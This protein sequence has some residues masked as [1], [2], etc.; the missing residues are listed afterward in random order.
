MSQ[1]NEHQRGLVSNTINAIGTLLGGNKNDKQKEELVTCPAVDED[2]AKGKKKAQEIFQKR[3]KLLEEQNQNVEFDEE[4]FKK[5][6]ISQ[7]NN[8][9]DKSLEDTDFHNSQIITMDM[10]KI[11]E[12]KLRKRKC[13]LIVEQFENLYPEMTVRTSFIYDKLRS[14]EIIQECNF[15]VS[16]RDTKK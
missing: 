6:I 15:I 2:L 7:I 3:K 9:M 16:D 8:A 4:K 1:I 10:G 13:E 5:E 12:V 14:G 11:K